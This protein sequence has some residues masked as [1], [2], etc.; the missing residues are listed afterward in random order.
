MFTK[1][2]SI[3][4]SSSI[5]NVIPG[6]FTHDDKL[7]L[8]VTSEGTGPSFNT[9][10]IGAYICIVSGGSGLSYYPSLLCHPTCY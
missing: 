5:Y 8:L 2:S 4:H 7:D 3:R 1:T 9:R 6:D 10:A